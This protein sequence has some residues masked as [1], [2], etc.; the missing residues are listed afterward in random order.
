MIETIA[1]IIREI[2]KYYQNFALA[3]IFVKVLILTPAFWIEF[4]WYLYMTISCILYKIYKKPLKEDSK[5][6]PHVGVIITAFRESE[7]DI[8]RSLRTVI[9]QEYDGIIEV[10]TIFDT[11]RKTNL[12][13]KLRIPNKRIIKIIDKNYRGGR[14]SSLNMGLKILSREAKIVVALDADTSLDYDAIKHLVIPFKNPEIIAVSGN[15]YVRNKKES[16]VT[17]LQHIEYII[18]IT[19]SRIALSYLG[20]V[21]NISGAYGAFRREFLEKLYGWDSGTAEDLNLTNRL[22]II[23]SIYENSKLAFV[24]ESVAH[25]SVPSTWSA[26]FKQ[27]QRW[28][29]DLVWIFYKKYR[30]FLLPTLLKPTEYLLFLNHNLLLQF[31]MP[32]AMVIYCIYIWLKYGLIALITINIFIFSVYEL[33]TAIFFLIYL[34]LYCKDIEE[35]LPF[36]L[37]LPLYPIYNWI[38]R[39]HAL[40]AYLDDLLLDLHRYSGYVPKWISKRLHY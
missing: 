17:R 9:H 10:V 25:T 11:R 3:D 19:L 36:L 23:S 8:L 38:L 34:S 40:K 7:R 12:L 16:L 27:R 30:R 18:S 22:K 26:L 6:S 2:I 13:K 4:P 37:V 32:C 24:P 15:L 29:G 14:A 31:I 20:T 35:E 39:I 33:W 21:N 1:Y 5:F 28:D